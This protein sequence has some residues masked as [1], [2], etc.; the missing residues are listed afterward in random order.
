MKLAAGSGCSADRSS[1]SPDVIA[2]APEM[3]VTSS[4]FEWR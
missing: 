2:K 3:T 4:S 1:F